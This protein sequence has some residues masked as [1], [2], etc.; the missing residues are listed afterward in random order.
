MT[1]TKAGY[2]FEEL[3]ESAYRHTIGELGL[4][5][6]K[7][8]LRLEFECLQKAHDAIHEFMLLASQLFPLKQTSKISWRRKSAFFTFHWEAFHHAHR[9]LIE[10]LC[11]YYN[12]AFVLLRTTLEIVIKGAFWECMSHKEYRQNCDV[13]DNDAWGKRI[14]GWLNE[15]FKLSE[16][17]KEEFEETSAGIY[18]K[19]GPI[20]E[21]SD[22]RP[23]IKTIVSQ[24]AQ[25][26]IFNPIPDPITTIYKGIYGRLS[27]D[28]HVVPNRTD[29]GKRILNMPSQI[30]DQE[31]LQDPLSEYAHCLHEV[32][33]LAIVVELNVM[34]NL[35][36]RYDEVKANLWE[37]IETLNQLG[38][39]YS[40]IRAKELLK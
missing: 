9:S 39:K 8:S 28:A 3:V 2:E 31:I 18:D 22:F 4:E 10:A 11:A 33:D 15:I 24:L 27:A 40:L 16:E 23:N 12:V 21:V 38:L 37:R 5:K 36:G 20:I 29:I 19:I 13:L 25:W 7:P 17:V 32:M 6:V 30:F 1:M 26:D 34:R 14:K 35:I